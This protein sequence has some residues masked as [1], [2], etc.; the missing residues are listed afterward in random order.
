MHCPSISLSTGRL[1]RNNATKFDQ[2]NREKI[3]PIPL[4]SST[5]ANAVGCSEALR[6]AFAHCGWHRCSELLVEPKGRCWFASNFGWFVCKTSMDPLCGWSRT[7]VVVPA[8][9]MEALFERTQK[10]A[11]KLQFTILSV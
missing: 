9:L 6:S 11:A 10:F 5:V 4:C 8:P 3:L 2:E 7:C 1:N